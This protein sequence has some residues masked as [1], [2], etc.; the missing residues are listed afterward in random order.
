[1]SRPRWF[2]A[3]RLRCERLQCERLQCERLQ[4]EQGIMAPTFTVNLQNLTVEGSLSPDKLKLFI[5]AQRIGEVSFKRSDLIEVL[6]S[7]APL[8]DWLVGV[9]DDVVACL[10]K[11]Q[12][13]TERLVARGVMPESGRDGKLVLLV[14]KFSERG[15]VK[16][17]KHGYADFRDLHL[18]DNVSVGQIVGRVYPPKPGVSGKDALG[19]ALPAPPGKPAVVNL[20]ATIQLGPPPPGEDFQVLISQSDGFVAEETGRLLVKSELV[21]K[22]DLGPQLGNIDFVGKVKVTGDVGP[23]MVV[24]ARDGIEVAGGVNGGSLVCTTGNIVVKGFF[25]GGAQSEIVCGGNVALSVAQDVRAEV[26]GT[27]SVEREAIDCR[28]RT[29]AT[30]LAPKCSL[31]GGEILCVCGVEAREIGNDS[32]KKTRV[33]LCS[34]VETSTDFSRLVVQI[35]SVETAV[36][37]VKLHLGP[38]ALTPDRIQLLREPHRTK[39]L[40]LVQKLRDLESTRVVLVAKKTRLLE[41]ARFNDSFQVNYLATFYSG[42]IIQTGDALFEPRDSLI[43]PGSVNFVVDRNEFVV[44]PLKPIT[45]VVRSPNEGEE[46]KNDGK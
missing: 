33:V 2:A 6:S 46:A 8:A 9:I 26:V 30:L 14:K 21:I 4:C 15:S 45:C 35:E 10:N 16:I 11:G 44:G 18:F 19:N 22:G 24:R 20:D 23:G 5:N 34:D 3:G 42:S 17:D 43:G 27:I 38:L 1:M 36:R 12:V 13:V 37:L 29:Q 39:M 41:T 32:G 40:K 28:F 25:F 7:K 31:V